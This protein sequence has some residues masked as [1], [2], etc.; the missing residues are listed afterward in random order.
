MVT[1]LDTGEFN[2]IFNFPDKIGGITDIGKGER[3]ERL[4]M[5]VYE[6]TD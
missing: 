6:T 3:D 1:N 5:F 4:D 2:Y